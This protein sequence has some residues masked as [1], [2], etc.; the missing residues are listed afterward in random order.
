MDVQTES[1][2]FGTVD[3]LFVEYVKRSAPYTMGADHFHPYYE[4]YYMLSGSRIYFVGDRSYPVEQGDLVF[5]KPNVLHQTMH[6]GDPEHE[7]LVVHFGDAF[8]NGFSSL[9]RALLLSPFEQASKV[10]R[11]PRQEQLPVDRQLRRLADELRH[12]PAGYEL[13]PAAAVTDLLLTAAR[14]LQEHDPVPI[15]HDTPLHAKISEIVRHIDAHFA[16]P[17]TLRELSDRFYISPHYLSRKFKEITGF[18]YTDYLVLTRIKEAQ[19]LLR[20]TDKSITEVAAD[21]GFDNFSHFG[22]T[23]KRIAKVPPRDYRKQI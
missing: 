4:I 23:F 1:F 14:Y 3:R 15:H 12:K 20:E 17:L 8:L 18:A 11:L 10:I 2:R 21:V 7:R 22:K 13:V 16:E 19:R 5:I 6:A 9:H